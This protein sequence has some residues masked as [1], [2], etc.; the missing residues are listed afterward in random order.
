MPDGDGCYIDIVGDAVAISGDRELVL[1]STRGWRF[2]L[3]GPTTFVSAGGARHQLPRERAA[4]P[5]ADLMGDAARVSSCAAYVDGRLELTFDDGAQVRVDPHLARESWVAVG[6]RGTRI[7]SLPGG[8]LA[9]S[10]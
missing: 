5:L 3:D 9:L 1:R 8:A 10:R 7:T 2:D 6:P 4:Q